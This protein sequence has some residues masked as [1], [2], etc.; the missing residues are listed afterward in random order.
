MSAPVTLSELQSMQRMAAAMVI[1]DPIYLPI[2]ERIE[3][4]LAALE[5]QGDAISRARAIAA[6]YK[7][8]A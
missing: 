5:A 8:A 7:A 2:F 6:R 3:Q 4:E 1:A